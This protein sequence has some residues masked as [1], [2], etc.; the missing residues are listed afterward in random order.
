VFIG[1]VVVVVEI[2]TQVSENKIKSL[3]HPVAFPHRGSDPPSSTST[4]PDPSSDSHPLQL[5]SAPTFILQPSIR[6]IQTPWQ[7]FNRC[8]ADI[9]VI[10]WDLTPSFILN[11]WRRQQN[12]S[13]VVWKVLLHRGSV[14]P[15]STVA[16]RGLSIWVY[17]PSAP[18]R[19]LV[20]KLIGVNVTVVVAIFIRS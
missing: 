1:F 14:G 12:Y 10:P 11:L 7:L 5:A 15:T 8:W 9:F 2:A 16:T 20:G 4:S 3:H 19:P 6:S 17:A 18:L 13:S